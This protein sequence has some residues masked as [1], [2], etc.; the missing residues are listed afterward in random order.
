MAKGDLA[1]KRPAMTLAVAA[2]AAMISCTA[3]AQHGR[4]TFRVSPGTEHKVHT[5]VGIGGARAC[6]SFTSAKTKRP[7]QA[8]VRRSWNGRPKDLDIHYNYCPRSLP[9]T[10]VLYV[11]ALKEETIVTVQGQESRIVIPIYRSEWM[12]AAR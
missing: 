10:Y 11:T 4:A 8:K 7:I 5:I 3:E 12:R 6:L 9:G 2:A 1:M